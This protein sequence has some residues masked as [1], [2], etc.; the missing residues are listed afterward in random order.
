MRSPLHYI[1]EFDR[2]AKSTDAQLL[3]VYELNGQSQLFAGYSKSSID[4][5]QLPVL[6]ETE[7]T[8]FVKLS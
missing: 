8:I 7:N 5:D 6:Q 3:Y 2:K 1:F 4:K